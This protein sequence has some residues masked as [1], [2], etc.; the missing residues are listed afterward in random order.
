MP[1]STRVGGHRMNDYETYKRLAA[2]VAGALAIGTSAGCG[3][4]GKTGDDQPPGVQVRLSASRSSTVAL[5][6]DRAHVAMVNPEDGSLSI[7]Q[8]SDQTRSAKVATGGN[9]SSV[10]IAADSKTAFVANRADGTVVRVSGIDGATPAI[11][12][13]VS[14]GAE[15]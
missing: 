14:V 9:P 4:D 11:D 15:P 2:A 13:T 7:F 12:G 10:V 6:D 3:D 5:A 1:S 8:T